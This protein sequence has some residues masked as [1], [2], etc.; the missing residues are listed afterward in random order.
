MTTIAKFSRIAG[1][2]L[3]VL[4]L[5]MGLTLAARLLGV[6]GGSHSPIA[7]YGATA[8]TWLAIFTVGYLVAAVG[9]WIGSAWGYVLAIGT[10]ASAV[11]MALFGGPDIRLPAMDFLLALLV[12]VLAAGLFAIVEIKLFGS[13]HD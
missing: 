8:F 2:V 5:F 10:A 12:L 7:M 3:S 6:A 1:R 11:V 9:V 4:C 13:V